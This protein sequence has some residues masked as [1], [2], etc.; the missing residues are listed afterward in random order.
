MKS[1]RPFEE[2]RGWDGWDGNLK[3]VVWF[4]VGW[5]TWVVGVRVG[6]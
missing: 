4:E 6:L 5:R 1:G 2:R 3:G